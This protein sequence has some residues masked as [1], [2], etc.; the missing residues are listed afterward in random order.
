MNAL[1]SVNRQDR[2]IHVANDGQHWNSDMDARRYNARLAMKKVL[3]GAKGQRGYD[4]TPI[5]NLTGYAPLRDVIALRDMTRA[6]V[7]L[8]KPQFAAIPDPV[9]WVKED[10]RQVRHPIRLAWGSTTDDRLDA[11]VST[12]LQLFAWMASGTIAMNVGNEPALDEVVRSLALPATKLTTEGV[13][14]ICGVHHLLNRPADAKR[15]LTAYAFGRRFG[16]YLED[17]NARGKPKPGLE[18]R[19]LQALDAAVTALETPVPAA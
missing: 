17:R 14:A 16:T 4:V 13:Y 8:V 3:L 11:S 10:G 6:H 7:E 15:D 5:H 12:L 18:E 2:A 9:G 1:F 19:L